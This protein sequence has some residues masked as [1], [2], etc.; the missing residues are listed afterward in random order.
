MQRIYEMAIAEKC[1]L[2]PWLTL[3]L[4]SGSRTLAG[5]VFFA[6]GATAQLFSKVKSGLQ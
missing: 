5:V 6:F 1:H 3:R 2:K 4:A